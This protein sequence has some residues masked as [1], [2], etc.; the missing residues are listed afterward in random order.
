MNMHCEGRR[1][2]RFGYSLGRAT[3]RQMRRAT[4]IRESMVTWGVHPLT[5]TSLVR[6]AQVASVAILICVVLWPGLLIV[7]AL[8]FAR[9][10]EQADLKGHCC[11]CPHGNCQCVCC[12]QVFWDDDTWR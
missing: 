8:V 6:A 2:E 1:G 11:S 4:A 12:N 5:A 9:M 7:L 3:R 10:I